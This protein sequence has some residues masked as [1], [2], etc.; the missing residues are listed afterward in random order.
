VGESDRQDALIEDEIE[1]TEE[2]LA[3]GYAA[4]YIQLNCWDD[5]PDRYRMAALKDIYTAMRRVALGQTKAEALRTTG[6]F[7]R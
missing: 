2:M 1:V 4:F 3:A 6:L 5:V 7:P